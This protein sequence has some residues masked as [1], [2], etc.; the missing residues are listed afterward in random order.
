MINFIQNNNYKNLNNFAFQVKKSE[1]IYFTGLKDSFSRGD[2]SLRTL[3]P[4]GVDKITFN[5]GKYPDCQFL[6]AINVLSKNPDGVDLLRKIIEIKDG[7]YKITFQKYPDKPVF[8]TNDEIASQLT[9]SSVTPE[10]LY[11]SRVEGD[12]GMKILEVAYAKL[13]KTAYPEKF[14]Q[15]PDDEIL[16]VFLD[17]NYHYTSEIAL[18]DITGWKVKTIIA[19]GGNIPEESQSFLEESESKPDL[20]DK[21]AQYLDFLAKEP[22][23]FVVVACTKGNKHNADYLDSEN[24]F[25]AWHDYSILKINQEKREIIVSNPH[26]KNH[27]LTISYD[28]FFNYFNLI[29]VAEVEKSITN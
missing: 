6:V 20:L 23:K 25:F 17:P 1:K 4:K 11:R 28:D 18:E 27:E 10:R 3:F 14:Q 19:N 12:L 8:V 24:K 9:K 5:Q 2:D 21:I 13:M 7:A 15:I 29:S 22:D 26:K 16:T